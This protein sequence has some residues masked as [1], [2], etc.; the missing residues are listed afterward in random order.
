MIDITRAE[1]L[2]FG[3]GQ[4]V[5]VYDDFEDANLKYVVPL[6]R[7]VHRDVEG[8]TQPVFTLIEFTVEGGARRG[9]LTFSVELDVPQDAWEAVKARYPDARFGQLRW[10]EA[11]VYL[12]FRVR[13]TEEPRIFVAS[14][15][16]AGSNQASYVLALQSADE[17][18]FIK[19]NFG[20]DA[21]DVSQL[22][23]AFDVTTLTKLRAVTA[24]VSFDASRALDY[25][26]T[27]D[28]K[29]NM[30]GTVTDR[31]ETIR[32]NLKAS[33]SGK[34]L[35]D[36]NI[37]DPSAE[38]RQRVENW[39]FG[40]LEGLV[41]RAVDEAAERLGPGNADK[42]SA[43]YLAS[44]SRSYEE[45]QVIEWLISPN[46]FLPAAAIRDNWERH[47]Q[48]VDFR[49]L[50]TT[51]TVLGALEEAGIARVELDVRY[52][53]VGKT[54]VFVPGGETTVT[55]EADGRQDGEGRFDPNY[56]YS[57]RVFYEDGKSFQTEAPIETAQTEVTLNLAELGFVRVIFDG[58]NLDWDELDQVA[59][60]FFF[61]PPADRAPVN[62]TK[63]LRQGQQKVPFDNKFLLRA[64]D[65][66]FNYQLAFR[67][68]D[69]TLYRQ[70]PIR[71]AGASARRRVLLQNPL[72]ETPYT[73]AVNNVDDG[74]RIDRALLTGTYDDAIN[75]FHEQ[76]PLNFTT[77][78][79]DFVEQDVTVRAVVNPNASYLRLNGRLIKDGGAVLPI[80]DIYISGQETFLLLNSNQRPF[81]VKFDPFQVDWENGVTRVQVDV[82]DAVPIGG[83]TDLADYQRGLFSSSITFAPVQQADGAPELG[84]PTPPQYFSFD[85]G[86]DGQPMYVYEITYFHAD[87]GPSYSGEMTAS[88]GT[89]VLPKDGDSSTP[90]QHV[91]RENVDVETLLRAA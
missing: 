35:I 91:V 2:R 3:D 50:A 57:Y 61:Q 44:F 47:F 85:F 16:L 63:L 81:T 4:T 74:P 8:T 45:N 88:R 40:A 34:T 64:T 37:P 43:T 41:Q 66:T 59:V 9:T 52:G 68:K 90:V 55:F 86:I 15:S 13:E 71:E 12:S 30:W 77:G 89:V 22:L 26:K 60:G 73:V 29:K 80:N 70:S 83:S 32:Q 58:T 53:D 65:F 51:F 46:A 56:S 72:Q 33:E 84:A 54:F 67:L 31:K 49:K 39:A 14:P 36:Y 24:T 27:V 62:E 78:G 6:P 75:G 20:P 82:F 5:T 21:P 23:L 17:L 42:L 79:R 19:A 1:I 38:F 48:M 69:G 18:D 76:K 10:E 25:E 28:V 7:F 87:S 11:D